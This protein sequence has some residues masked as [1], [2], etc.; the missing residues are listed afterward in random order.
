MEVKTKSFSAKRTFGLEVF[1]SDGKYTFNISFEELNKAVNT[2]LLHH[3]IS[4]L[5]N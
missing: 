4:L 2:T 3:N 1:E 5:V